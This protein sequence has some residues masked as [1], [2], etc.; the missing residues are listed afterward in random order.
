MS[1]FSDPDFRWQAGALICLLVALV[2]IGR[3]L[4]PVA[5]PIRM[6]GSAAI[7]PVATGAALALL[8]TAA[9]TAP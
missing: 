7:V 8:L 2:F 5:P 1:W 6:V 3:A 9:F 4:A